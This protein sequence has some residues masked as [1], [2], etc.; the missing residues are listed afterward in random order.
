MLTRLTIQLCVLSLVLMV[1]GS[2]SS[3]ASAAPFTSRVDAQPGD[4]EEQR[5]WDL[6]QSLEQDM[7]RKNRVRP[8]DDLQDYLQSVLDKLY[9]EF[10]GRMRVRVLS[11][12]EV[13]AFTTASG[14]IFL[15]EGLLIRLENEAQLATV[16]AH[17]GIH[18]IHRH[19]FILASRERMGETASS[20]AKTLMNSAN[21]FAKLGGGGVGEW[22]VGATK[23]EALDRAREMV[24]DTFLATAKQRFD[25]FKKQIRK[26]V[27]GAF[28]GLRPEGFASTSI[29]GFSGGMEKEADELG[30][31]RMVQ[32]GYA[33]S[34]AIKLFNL[35]GEEMQR[36]SRAEFF[37]FS[38]IAMLSDREASFK[39]L[40]AGVTG[41]RLGETEFNHH[42]NPIRMVS[43]EKEISAGRYDALLNYF[44]GEQGQ[45]RLALFP[46]QVRFYLGEAYRIR[47]AEGDL[48][49]AIEQYRLVLASD[50]RHAAAWRSLGLSYFH[51]QNLKAALE[52]LQN[53]LS[54]SAS[55]ADSAYTKQLLHLVNAALQPDALVSR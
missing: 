7:V 11:Q 30:M 44:A 3:V 29:F 18:F 16:L 24:D 33:P 17:E 22:A 45:Q 9:P 43:I 8:P 52:A 4:V 40:A 20:V 5:V 31:Q 34:E 36:R 15:T 49:K 21:P 2:F 35:L 51:Q 47:S 32:A 37:F 42:V 6:S 50:V 14:S 26:S 46:V 1:S 23:S 13:N 19:A 48:D 25:E 28:S 12:P 53:S 27:T 10:T 38:S 55:D 39:S 41:Q 54:P